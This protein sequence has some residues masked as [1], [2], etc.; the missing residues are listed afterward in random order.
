MVP[1]TSPGTGGVPCRGVSG[2]KACV[3]LWDEGKRSRLDIADAVL[4]LADA[5]VERGATRLG[6]DVVDAE[7]D[8]PSPSPFGRRQHL[9]CALL[10]VWFDD[11]AS[12]EALE[13]LLQEAVFRHA[14]YRVEESVYT[15]WGDNEHHPARDWPDT[16]RS[17][18]VVTLNLIER[19]PGLSR[20]TWI[21]RWHD[22]LSPVTARIQPRCRYVRNLVLEPLTDGAP[23]WDGI[24]EE[25]FADTADLTNPFRFYGA[26]RN[27]IRLLWN[28]IVV[29]IVVMRF[30]RIWR[31]RTIPMGEYFWKT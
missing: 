4:E 20:E 12:L 3:L 11:L 18:G 15:D 9:P 23:P 29:L 1:G 27:P 30:T 13:P 2:S 22:R 17:P 6:I 14:A 10:N 24:V 5:I 19:P 25:C 16:N 26:G 8:V 7:S 31:V 28:L 21:R